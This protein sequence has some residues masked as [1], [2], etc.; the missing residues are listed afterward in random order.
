MGERY[1]YRPGHP[2]ADEFNFVR[3]DLVG[4]TEKHGTAPNVI[5]DVEPFVSPVDKT[6]ITSRSQIREH[7]KKHG[8]RQIG[9]DWTG[10][11]RPQWWDRRKAIAR[12]GNVDAE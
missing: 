5:S 1:I 10:R 4:T 8:V 6:V 7:E 3:A 11:E 12:T 2:E 9:N